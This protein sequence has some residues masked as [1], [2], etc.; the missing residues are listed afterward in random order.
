MQVALY[1]EA[2]PGFLSFQANDIVC[3][4]ETKQ[5]H[6]FS[7]SLNPWLL[8]DNKVKVE[9][10]PPVPVAELSRPSVKVLTHSPEVDDTVL[11]SSETSSEKGDGEK[12]EDAN[13]G[14]SKIEGPNR[15]EIEKIW[16]EIRN[17]SSMITQIELS[18]TFAVTE[19]E[20]TAWVLASP[21]WTEDTSENSQAVLYA[22]FNDVY[23]G[24]LSQNINA[25]I[26]FA[27]YK[28]NFSSRIFQLE[29]N[30]MRERFTKMITRLLK[31][32]NI[33]P[34]TSASTEL[35]LY[36]RKENAVY[37]FLSP[38]GGPPFAVIGDS[39][40]RQGVQFIVAYVDGN[41]RWLL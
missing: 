41:W 27:D 14:E 13:D 29:Q 17:E 22:L 21:P 11:F 25:I 3:Y 35:V 30:V 15:P 23:N 16:T 34:V 18:E 2:G 37:E 10:I 40:F 38:S 5:A 19:S 6:S 1:I 24:L 32:G 4:A 33:E 26:G 31:A 20:N 39:N 9:F 28:I 7:C 12:S 8:R 36:P